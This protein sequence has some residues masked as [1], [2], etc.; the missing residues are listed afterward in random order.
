MVDDKEL[1]IIYQQEK[2]LWKHIKK[3]VII[4][5]DIMSVS[6]NTIILNDCHSKDIHLHLH[7]LLQVLDVV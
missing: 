3:Y 1:H 6:Q 4:S 7:L 5:P 2:E